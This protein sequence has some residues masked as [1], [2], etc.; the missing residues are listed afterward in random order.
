M[1]KF[2]IILGLLAFAA[3]LVLFAHRSLAAARAKG[4]ISAQVQF[5]A[6]G[7]IKWMVTILVG[8]TILQELGVSLSAMWATISAVLLVV[9]I[10]FVA[11]WSVLS[12]ALCAVFLVVFAPFRIGDEIE[13]M[14]PS[15]HE[16]GKSGLRGTVRDITMLYTTLEDPGAGPGEKVCVRV[17]N[18]L[19]FQKAVKCRGGR[20][21]RSLRQALMDG[22]LT[23]FGEDE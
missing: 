4:Y 8:V 12:N 10:G 11:V 9:A 16:E 15:V 18:N 13:I 22:N 2:A 5:I 20:E 21:T 6:G 19:F 3:M 7:T 1:S 17:P 23:R 14:E